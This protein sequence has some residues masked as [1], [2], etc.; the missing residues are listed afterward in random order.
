[1][2]IAFFGLGNMGGPMACHLVRAGYRVK[3]YD[4]VPEAVQSFVSQGGQG[5]ISVEEALG[6]AEV[7]I[8]MLP[9][10]KIAKELYLGAGGILSHVRP[11]TLL[12]DSSTIAAVDAVEM[13]HAA[14]EKGLGLVDAP[15]SGGV[16]GAK[17]ATLTFIVGGE[18]EDFERAQPVLSKMGKTIFHAGKNGA[19]QVAKICNNML[20][21]VHM[22]GTCEALNLG[23][24]HGLD[25]KVLSEIMQQSSGSNWS[26]QKY[27]PYPRVMPDSPA[28][29]GY[30]GGFG[31]KLMLKDLKLAQSAAREVAAYTPLG[32]LAEELYGH[33]GQNEADK[34]FSSILKYIMRETP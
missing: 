31:V 30:E 10:G 18:L 15:V 17:A 27:N 1:M 34:D 2:Q 11:K 26:L 20:L 32:T 13:A 16:G 7:V 29:Q 9:S 28:S 33:H 8:T 5:A 12:V 3:G 4:V 6:G 24:K 22:I 25:P 19:G 23:V 14:R 21:A